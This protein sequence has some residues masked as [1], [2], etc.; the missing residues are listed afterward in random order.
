MSTEEV[1]VLCPVCRKKHR[2]FAEV[3]VVECKGRPMALFKDRHGWRLMEIKVISERE[4][5]ELDKI[6]K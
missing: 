6:W 3:Q 2:Y 5:E 4:D 1:E